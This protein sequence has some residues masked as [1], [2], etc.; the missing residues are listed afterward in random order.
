MTS[1]SYYCS[2]NW[3]EA[4]CPEGREVEVLLDGEYQ[5]GTV[6][7]EMPDFEHLIVGLGKNGKRRMLID[8]M[9]EWFIVE[10]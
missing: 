2:S 3:N 10:V 9:Q 1:V 4:I 7:R 6:V 8:I 5:R